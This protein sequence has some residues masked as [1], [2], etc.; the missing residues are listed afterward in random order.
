MFLTVTQIDNIVKIWT[1][2]QFNDDFQIHWYI[3]IGLFVILIPMSFVRDIS[4]FAKVH[5]IGDIAVVAVI[6]TLVSTSIYSL[7]SGESKGTHIDMTTK[8]WPITLGMTV[9]MLEG[10]GLVL[11]IKVYIYNLGTNE[12]QRRFP[13]DR[14]N[15]TIYSCN[16]INRVPSLCV[17]MFPG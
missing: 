6:I 5:I 12:K 16:D 3:G 8:D 9:T 10:V 11:P 4:K 7:T 15:R 17:F 14:N 13:K 1:G 2:N